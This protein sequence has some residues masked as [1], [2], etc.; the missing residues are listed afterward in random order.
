MVVKGDLKEKRY[1]SKCKK[2]V[3]VMPSVF[4]QMSPT[5]PLCGSILL[6]VK[7]INFVVEGSTGAYRNPR[8]YKKE[9]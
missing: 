8:K 4:G 1:C 6:S 5:C 3:K 9:S 7:N 2:H